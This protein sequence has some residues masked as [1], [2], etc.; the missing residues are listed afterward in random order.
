MGIVNFDRDAKPMDVIR[1]L[2]AAKARGQN[3]HSVLQE[4]VCLL[5]TESARASLAS[6]SSALKAWHAFAVHILGM[7]AQATLP[8]RS[9]TQACEFLAI[10][11][12]GKTASNYIGYVKWTCVHLNLDVSWY[13]GAVRQTLGGVHKR[14]LR[15]TG[16][17]ARVAHLLTSAVL[18]K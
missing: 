8:P 17:P 14:S 18:N 5:K 13:G 12:S 15:Y 16:G 9:E 7:P 2:A 3:P 1:R 4:R 10:F 11:R 6:V